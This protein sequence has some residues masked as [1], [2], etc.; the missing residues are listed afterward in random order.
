MKKFVPVLF[1]LFLSSCSNLSS[2][3]TINFV[4]EEGATFSDPNFSTTFITGESN[5]IIINGLPQAKKE[6]Y[7]FVGWREYIN[8]S[9]QF[10]QTRLIT[11]SSSPFYGQEVYLY[12]YGTTT[13]YTYFEPEETFVFDLNIGQEYSPELIAPSI[14]NRDFDLESK[15]LYGYEKKEF[16]SSSYLPTAKCLNKTFSYWAIEYPLV[17]NIDPNTRRTFFI[18]DYSKEKG[19]YNFLDFFKTAQSFSFPRLGENNN[20]LTLKAIWIDNTNVTLDLGLEGKVTSFFA[21]NQN[22]YSNIIESIEENFGTITYNEKQEIFI[23]DE[24]YKLIGCYLD[25]EHKYEFPISSDIA[26]VSLNLYLLWGKRIDVVLDF[27]G[28]NINNETSLSYSCYGYD[29][30][31]KEAYLELPTKENSYFNYYSYNENKVN[32]SS[33]VLPNEDITLVANFT[34][35]PL[36][37][38]SYSFPSSYEVDTSIFADKEIILESGSDI[39]SYLSSFISTLT[40]TEDYQNKKIEYDN[41]YT[42]INNLETLFSSTIMPGASLYVYLKIYYSS[43]INLVSINSST[44][45]E[46]STIDLGYLSSKDIN[47]SLSSLYSNIYDDVTYN[48]EILVYDGLYFD[49]SLV[50]KNNNE[51]ISGTK[52]DEETIINVYRKLTPG[53][54]FTFY[55]YSSLYL[56]PNTPISSYSNRIAN[57]LGVEDISS[58][59]FYV[60]VDGTKY[61]IDVLPSVETTIYVE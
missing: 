26:E 20:S 57:L 9:Y 4:L 1:S 22:I 2:K 58:L 10:L 55:N 27:N 52:S 18:V 19:L 35:F 54:K 47:I 23:K 12:P 60:L 30:L 33:F 3:G 28:G 45:L 56:I 42:T 39:S 25:S 40:N 48:S 53:V 41:F 51:V 61:Y 59:S 43:I 38:L 14:P 17:E 32:L 15:T 16:S 36:L 8:G 11:D 7:Y 6:G 49:S 13:L 34:S 50:T 5:S 24:E 31:P 29:H 21:Q 44:S 46:I 37:Y